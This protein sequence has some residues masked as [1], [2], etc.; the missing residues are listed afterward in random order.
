MAPTVL[1]KGPYRF[2]FYSG[3]KYE[4]VH[5]HV[6][7]ESYM[8]KFWLDPVVLQNNN[9]F[10]RYE[11]LKIEKIIKSNQDKIKEAWYDYFGS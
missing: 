5:V 4:P 1:K 2:F 3:D 7:R 10:N 8:A 11:L 9:G 6:E